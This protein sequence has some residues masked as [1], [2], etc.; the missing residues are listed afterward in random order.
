MQFRKRG[1]VFKNPFKKKTGARLLDFFSFRFG[2]KKRSG[3]KAFIRQHH[4]M[5][6][7]LL[8]ALVAGA[9]GGLYDSASKK[10]AERP[11]EVKAAV[12]DVWSPKDSVRNWASVAMSD[13]GKYQTAVV[14]FGQIYISSDYGRTWTAVGPTFRWQ[15]V[16]M[17]AYG[18][19]QTAVI[20][21]GQ[22]YVS[23]DRGNTWTPKDASRIWLS[24]AVSFNGALQTATVRN[25]QIYIS[26]D[27]GST[28]SP[29]ETNRNWASVAMSDSGLYQTA[30]NLAAGQ[31]YVSADS[32][33]TWTPKES[34]RNWMS[35]AMSADGS[36]QT[37]VAYSG[38]IYI[39][40]D[41]GNTWT[42]KEAS[43][44]WE[45][46]AMSAD[47]SRQTAV[48]YSGQIYMS[49]DY[50]NAWIAKEANR[51][52]MSVDMIR[53]GLI[54]TAVATGDFIYTTNN[55]SSGDCGTLVDS[56]DGKSYATVVIGSNCWMKQGL[57]VG[58]RIAGS[59]VQ[60][61]NCSSAAAIQKYCYSDTDA[62]CDS[63]N[64]PNFPDGGLYMWGQAMCGSVVE[65]A[66]GICPIGWHIPTT[67]DF[68]NL[69]QTID[70]TISC[71]GGM[72]SNAGIHLKTTGLSGWEG[73][74]AGYKY[75]STYSNRGS[76]GEFWTSWEVSPTLARMRDL[77]ASTDY[78]NR[79][80][81]VKTD[82]SNTVRCVKVYTSD[83][84]P[85]VRSNGAPTG[86]L[87]LGTTQTNISVATDEGALCKYSTT[88]GE[89]FNQQ[90]YL[91]WKQEAA[92]AWPGRYGHK[93]AV[94]NN[95]L[96]I[97]GGT[98]GSIIYTNDVWSTNDGVNW[99]ASV[100][101]PWSAR[102]NFAATEFQ[103]KIWVMGGWDG[104]RKNDVWSFDGTTWT[105]A[106]NAPWIARSGM[107]AVNYN[108][109]LW[110][111]GGWDGAAR[112]DVWSFDGTTWTVEP[113][114]PAVRSDYATAVYNGRLWVLGGWDGAS[115]RNTVWSFDGTAWTVET[116]FSGGSINYHPAVV[117]N[118][119][120]WLMGSAGYTN[121]AWTFDG[122]TW[123]QQTNN[124]TP[125][126]SRQNFPAAVYD[127][128][129]FVLGG[130]DP[131]FSNTIWTTGST[132][133]TRLVTGLT[134]GSSY[135]YYVRCEDASANTDLA[136]YTISFSVAAADAIPPVRSGGSP[137]GALPAGTTQT[138]I[139]LTTDENAICKLS[140]TADMSYS[141]IPGTFSTTGGTSHSVN[142]SGLSDGS[143][144]NYYARCQ[145]FAG[146]TI[147]SV[148]SPG[149][150][151]SYSSSAIG[152][153]G[154]MVVSYYDSTNGD[155]KVA[156]CGNAS[157]SSGNTITTVDSTGNVGRESAITIGADG[158]PVISYMDETNG[159]LKVAKCGNASCSSGNTITTVDSAGTVGRNSAIAINLNNLPVISYIDASNFDLKFLRCGDEACTSGNSIIMLDTAGGTGYGTSITVGSDNQP[160]ISY[161]E[162]NVGALKVAKCGNASCSSGNTLTIVDTNPLSGYSS[163]IKPQEN[164]RPV[165]SYYDNT[166]YDLKVAICGNLACSSG[167][168]LTTVDSSGSVGLY[169]SLVRGSD[170][171]PVISYLDTTN[172]V[173]KVVK[174]G[175]SACSSGNVFTVLD[176]FGTTQENTSMSIGADNLPAI[177]YFD[178]VNNDLKIIKC[179]NTNCSVN[180]NINPNDYAIS[181]SVA[182]S[183]PF[184]GVGGNVSGWG[185]SAGTGWINFSASNSIAVAP[186]ARRF[187]SAIET[188]VERAASTVSRIAKF[189]KLSFNHNLAL[190]KQK[191]GLAR[192]VNSFVD[193]LKLSI[194]I[195]LAAGPDFGVSI[196]TAGQFS[197]YAWSD[198]V[199]WIYFGPDDDLTAHGYGNI[200]SS[201]APS[202]PKIW[203]KW[204]QVVDQPDSVTGWANILALGA[205]GWIKMSD[206]SV[207]TW[208]GKGV[209]IQ[210]N[211]DFTGWAWNA[212]AGGTAGIGWISFN[213]TVCDLDGDGTVSAAE[214][215]STDCPAGP[216]PDF[217]VNVNLGSANQAPSVSN[218]SAPNWSY[219]DAAG[220]SG[221]KNAILRWVYSD[222]DLPPDL[223][224]GYQVIINTANSTSSPLINDTVISGS[225]QYQTSALDWNTPYYWWVRVWDVKGA[226]S[227][228][229]Q[230]SS[231]AD[232]DNN[233]GNNL[234]FTTYKHLFPLAKF[235]WSPLKP[236][237]DQNV[238]FIDQSQVVTTVGGV[239]ETATTSNGSIWLWTF[240]N[241][242]PA[243][244]NEA[245]PVAKFTSTGNTTVTLTITDS[246]GYYS[247][248]STNFS[249]KLKLPSWTEQKP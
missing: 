116:A 225:S 21:G 14:P 192:Y 173:I 227:S 181:F 62:N 46:V 190:N 165:I 208:V 22:I 57:N 33:N 85:P 191:T 224:G 246:D 106:A 68:C 223:Q 241:G 162:M 221:A 4:F 44:N 19:Y 199:G 48:V 200:A 65:G 193:S 96:W 211:G 108:G 218:L 47:G 249:A 215:A 79:S 66:Q 53:N 202:D 50:G 92:P 222:L 20:A 154:L 138:N 56:R 238:N 127:G 37:A 217:K 1:G 158:F 24:V 239:Y 143:S 207:G 176:N 17:S 184:T 100:N 71:P 244:S 179:G 142:V 230:Y 210:S 212:G 220:P 9:M 42:P 94:L 242:V 226:T 153:D 93:A 70:P 178:S 58:T 166:N 139:I 163:S 36:R 144:Y 18:W 26:I 103:N 35:V 119:R 141:T 23:T 203:A 136:D 102:I 156:K 171:L 248:T 45:S 32:G 95:R 112:N 91:F 235:T 114:M 81:A 213:A 10:L 205:D 12:G 161:G 206:A 186:N 187:A 170:G 175:N 77:Q 172:S 89:T 168:T 88:A 245:N 7:F 8:L 73:N 134:N 121:E 216:M 3:L 59:V 145:D 174:C 147:S 31:I 49:T 61:T 110:I 130:N 29:K 135:N 113:A 76:Y 25:G 54:Q 15:A 233:D 2:F 43:R 27:Y 107:H 204:S 180:A 80:N 151:G 150:V 118:N 149:T 124:F 78:L 159:D 83:T 188:S 198:A 98:T 111:L 240:D 236:S 189:F 30:V 209:S 60:G 185:W 51:N 39:S 74:F 69:E 13:D 117:M 64:N 243:N 11:G 148:D 90:K 115:S 247:S 41:S 197:G 234:T 157:C 120:I 160:A 129:I 97:F 169:T 104:A 152:T 237:K 82:W 6:G 131:G 34:N 177:S 183:G 55:Y 155:L 164:G 86:V 195:A 101:A 126:T 72:S 40:T 87:P 123:R 232:T 214:A 219:T 229:V 52:W 228:W 75:T 16:A 231:A 67:A 122:V 201:S 133:H 84:T 140:T 5:L 109:K 167:N 132:T 99:V 105:A 125:W 196:D 182:N 194:K 63:N 128:K 137:S 146:N 28:W 38:Q